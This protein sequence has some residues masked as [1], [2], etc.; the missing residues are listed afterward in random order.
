MNPMRVLLPALL[1][2]FLSN[3]AMAQTGVPTALGPAGQATR[4]TTASAFQWIYIGDPGNPMSPFGPG[5]VNYEY[6]I[7]KYEVTNRQYA[8]F[9][10]AK[11]ALGDPLELYNPQMGGHPSGGI[12]R[13]GAGQVGDPYVY[14]LRPLMGGKPVNFVSFFDSMRFAN[15]MHHG[16]GN[17]DTETGSYALV[18]GT[19]IPDNGSAVVRAASATV[20]VPTQHEWYKA[21]HYDRVTMS[22]SNFATGSDAIPTHAVATPIGSVANPGPN[23]VNYQNGADWNGEDGNVTTVGAT[24]PA[25]ESFYGCA[26]M[27]GNISEWNETKF[28]HNGTL[29]RKNRG[30]DYR[31]DESIMEPGHFGIVV[32]HHETSTIG[33]RVARLLP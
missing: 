4:S 18:G 6:L 8:E 3:M 26:D 21:G 12:S 2:T 30:G 11:A 13:A 7:G 31:L 25:S 33:F 28:Q 22:Y 15:W 29:Y 16:R 32:P 10:N 24:G 19:A 23:T 17:G 5:R 1:A 14:S 9:L 20:V 27:N